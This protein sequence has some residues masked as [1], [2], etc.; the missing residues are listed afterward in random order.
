MAGGEKESPPYLEYWVQPVLAKRLEFA[1]KHKERARQELSTLLDRRERAKAERD[2]H[3]KRK[4]R[5]CGI[6][7]HTGVGCSFGCIYCYIWDMGF[8]GKPK[9]YPL[10]PEA[11]A[12]ALAVNPYI[13][14]GYTFAA[15]G[16]VTEPFLEE[17]AELA[18]SYIK[19]VYKWL[20]LPSQ[21]STKQVLTGKLTN[22]LRET[23]PNLSILVSVSA[24]GDLARRLEPRAPPAEERLIAAGRAAREG[25][26]VALFV[27][28]IIPGV[29]DRQANELFEL[30]AES[31]IREVVLGSLRVTLGILRRLS[32]S[33]ITIPRHLLPRMPRSKRDQVTLRMHDIKMKVKL[34]AQTYG[35]I[36]HPTACS[37]NVHA[38]RM[39]CRRCRL[40][41]CYIE[42]AIPD[43]G[44]IREA[45]SILGIEK[46]YKVVRV[47]KEAIVLRGPPTKRGPADIGVFWLREV[48]GLQVKIVPP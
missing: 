41:P 17:T 6:T 16:S 12:Y 38:H 26:K 42:P 22:A 18:I 43:P 37:A 48:S 11:M 19:T 9:P 32:A 33:G 8:P 36:V 20:G 39:P 31:G 46:F 7:I 25:L 29:T 23:D 35:L 5:P 30:A 24:L 40:G 3:A 14:P 34:A 47:D 21:V 15:Y 45:L 44:E 4:P 27:R 1:L 2:H 13:V 28:P 10:S